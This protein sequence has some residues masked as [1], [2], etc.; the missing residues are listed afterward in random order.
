MKA[1]V[2]PGQGSQF[3]GMGKE[4]YDTLPASQKY[5]HRAD[6]ILGFKIS[7]IMFH[8]SAEDLL[9]T[10]V[11][12]PAIFLHSVVAG[13][14]ISE[15]PKSVAGHS[16]G[17]FS[18]LVC[19][20]ILDFEDALKLVSIRAK[21]MQRACD[22]NPS[23][24]AAILGLEDCVVEKLCKESLDTV[25]A[26]NYNAPGQLVISGQ[27]E[28]VRAVME[29][30]KQA[31]AKR[32]VTLGVNG[33]FHSPLMESARKELAAA[34]DR[35]YFREGVCPVY[36]NVTALPTYDPSDIK[37]NLIK[38]LTQPVLWSQSIKSMIVDG[39][40]EFVEVGPGKVLQGIIRKINREVTLSGV[41]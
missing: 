22:A 16:L 34:I 27:T 30:C 33:A 11:T 13:L 41:A 17:E 32:V 15:V 25:V 10:Q 7:D 21:A 2:F 23:S 12:Q 35:I 29:K 19:A 40:N 38:Q 8:G 5:F 26:A 3:S 1:F 24:M 6:E 9:Q 36:Q 37:A 39:F 20:K 18:A 14:K 31:G 4:I 28:A